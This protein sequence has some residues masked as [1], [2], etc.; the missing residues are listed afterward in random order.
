MFESDEDA[1]QIYNLR[2]KGAKT[3]LMVQVM[4]DCCNKDGWRQQYKIVLTNRKNEE[5]I[6]P[7][8]PFNYDIV[9]GEKTIPYRSVSIY[10]LK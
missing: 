8:Y 10:S 2:I 3:N 6:I 9:H 7:S 1:I 4:L 5:K